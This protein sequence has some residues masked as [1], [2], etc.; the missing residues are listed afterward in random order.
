MEVSPIALPKLLE[1]IHLKNSISP[2]AQDSL[3]EVETLK[4]A[5]SILE[6]NLWEDS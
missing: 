6:K 2:S 1:L 3:Y 4:E 5:W